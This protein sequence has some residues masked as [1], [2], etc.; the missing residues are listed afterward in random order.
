MIVSPQDAAVD[1]GDYWKSLGG[2]WHPTDWVHYEYPGFSAPAIQEP[3]GQAG[4]L[5]VIGTASGFIG[6][7]FALISLLEVAASDDEAK[8]IIDE[9]NYLT[10]SHVSYH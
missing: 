1:V 5:D 2:L 10:G 6:L 4:L 8:K 7:P 3:I 9:W